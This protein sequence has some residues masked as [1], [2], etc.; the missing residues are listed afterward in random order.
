MSSDQKKTKKNEATYMPDTE[1]NRKIYKK[2]RRLDQIMVS[3]D[4][5]NC[6][7]KV[8]HKPDW[9]Y[10]ELFN[11]GERPWKRYNANKQRKS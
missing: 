7:I 5:L 11:L 6:N 2:G 3:E 1:Q 4:L 10:Q 9:Q 8:I